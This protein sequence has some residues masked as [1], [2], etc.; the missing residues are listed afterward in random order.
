MRG[1]DAKMRKLYAEGVYVIHN[2]VAPGQ[3]RLEIRLY[4]PKYILYATLR[5]ANNKT[6]YASVAVDPRMFFSNTEYAVVNENTVLTAL[7]KFL[8]DEW[9]K[10]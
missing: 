7:I 2:G 9:G 6:A 10:T 8:Y 1:V 3:A 5:V 4:Y